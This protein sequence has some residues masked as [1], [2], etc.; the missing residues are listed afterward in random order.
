VRQRAT[1]R[2]VTFVAP[3]MTIEVELSGERLAGQILPPRSGH[4]EVRDEHGRSRIVVV[5]QSGCFV[6]S[7]PP[8]RSF[9]LHCRTDAG[10][11]VLTGWM[12]R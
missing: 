8:V 5:D 11:E 1:L 9:R 6:V 10:T 12:S 4:I 2:G 3:A 7:R